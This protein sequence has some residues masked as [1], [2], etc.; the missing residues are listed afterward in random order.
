MGTGADGARTGGLVLAGSL[1]WSRAYSD[2]V[3][4][5]VKLLYTLG[6]VVTS[7]TQKAWRLV[8]NELAVCL[9][10]L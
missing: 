5:R 9:G 7:S 10:Q 2:G 4:Q 1:V 8:R 3:N 6:R